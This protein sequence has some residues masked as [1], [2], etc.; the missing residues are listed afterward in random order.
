[1]ICGR[2]NWDC[3]GGGVGDDRLDVE[4]GGE[5]NEGRV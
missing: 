3:V 1:M 2:C 5:E 4:V